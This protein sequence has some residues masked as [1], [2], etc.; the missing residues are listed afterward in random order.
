[1]FVCGARAYIV[2]HAPSSLVARLYVVPL[3]AQLS[4]DFAAVGESWFAV[5][6]P[7]GLTVKY[8]CDDHM[9]W[10]PAFNGKGAHGKAIRVTVKIPFLEP[11]FEPL[12]FSWF[13]HC[14]GWREK[15]SWALWDHWFA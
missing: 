14:Q 10:F 6:R 2:H 1:M 8:K 7:F 13:Y 3:G 4:G 9:G 15:V 5:G 12:V 11:S